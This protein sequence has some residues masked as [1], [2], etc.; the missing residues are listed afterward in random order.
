MLVAVGSALTAVYGPAP[1]DLSSVAAVYEKLFRPRVL[2]YMICFVL[3]LVACYR[4]NLTRPK[5]VGDKVRGL[6]LGAGAGALAGN[7]YFCTCTMRLLR[8]GVQEG[9]WSAWSSPMPFGLL[10]G[11]M[12][13]ALGSI[14]ITSKGLQEY[15]ALFMVTLF[16]GFHIFS[17]CL[18]GCIVLDEMNG[19]SSSW[20]MAVYISSV[21]CVC[22]GL[23]IVQTA[24][25]KG[26]VKVGPEA[27][28]CR[29]PVPSPSDRQNDCRG[30]LSRGSNKNSR[31]SPLAT[32]LLN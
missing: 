30:T 12:G 27:N 17:A 11:T 6:T 26:I 28:M 21:V 24:S 19:F 23:Y 4:V 31:K 20:Q 7:M 2:A 25:V 18:S 14:P 3:F 10:F 8:V 22:A 15:E 9:D 13:I 29:P 1:A 5:G 32:P 16:E